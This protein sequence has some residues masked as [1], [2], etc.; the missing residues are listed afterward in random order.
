MIINIERQKKTSTHHD[1]NTT[2]DQ[3]ASSHNDKTSLHNV[4]TVHYDKTPKHLDKISRPEEQRLNKN[5]MAFHNLLSISNNKLRVKV[6]VTFS[7]R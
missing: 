2:R 3:Q 4:A 6:S 5:V 1:G 7:L